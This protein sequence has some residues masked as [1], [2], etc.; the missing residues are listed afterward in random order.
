MDAAIMLQVMAGPDPGD[1]RT[2]GAP[3]VADYVSAA[4]PLSG[5]GR[6]GIRWPTRIGV[7]P[8]YLDGPDEPAAGPPDPPPDDPQ[9]LSP[10]R[11]ARAAR[12]R[13]RRV[14][15]TEARRRMLTTFEELGAEVIEVPLPPDWDTLTSWD[16]NNVR[17]PERA[18]P[19][20]EHL[21]QDVRLF[22]VSLS[23][24]IN[25]LLLPGTEYLR[26]QRAKL[27]LLRRVLDD[28]FGACDVVVQTSPIP[29][30]MIG[31][32][33]IAFPTGFHDDGGRPLPLGAVLGGRPWAED[34]LLSLVAAYQAVTDWHTRRPADPTPV[35]A[36]AGTGAGT[37]AREA[38]RPPPP[39]ARGRTTVWEIMAEGA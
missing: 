18:E 15:E 8:G 30:D 5:A 24:W 4:T 14:A 33:L 10:E 12:A 16:F 26:G 3:P 7:L 39:G 34:R 20:L 28:L 27:L 38:R 22:G 6:P 13:A 19:F 1:A 36:G 25:G 37:G 23:P 35:G 17:L 32:P 31:L 2:L 29:F 9:Q 21:K 11:A